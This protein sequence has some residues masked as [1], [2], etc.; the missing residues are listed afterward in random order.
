M[1]YLFS[2][3][4][5]WKGNLFLSKCKGLNHGVW[6]PHTKLCRVTPTGIILRKPACNYPESIHVCTACAMYCTERAAWNHFQTY[7]HSNYLLLRHTGDDSLRLCADGYLLLLNLCCH[8]LLLLLL[9]WCLLRRL[10][11]LLLLL[12]LLLHRDGLMLGQLKIVLYLIW[13]YNCLTNWV[14]TRMMTSWIIHVCQV[15]FGNTSYNYQ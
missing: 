15:Q 6:H 13:G 4:V 10:L 5:V 9:W 12:L 3:K 2:M 11:S 14:L 1:K 7:C 8:L